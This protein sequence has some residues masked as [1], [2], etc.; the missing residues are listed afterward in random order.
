MSAITFSKWSGP[1]GIEQFIIDKTGC[2]PY[3]GAG[4]NPRINKKT[5]ILKSVDNTYYSD[6]MEIKMKTKQDL[7]NLYLIQKKHHIYISIELYLIIKI[8]TCGMVNMK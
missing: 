3:S 1:D 6:T 5:T 8:N 7:M 2:K 4:I